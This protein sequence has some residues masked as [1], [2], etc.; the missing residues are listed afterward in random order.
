LSDPPPPEPPQPDGTP[1]PASSS[2]P[3]PVSGQ[4]WSSPSGDPLSSDP[5]VAG[6]PAAD[7][8]S[9]D[10]YRP[11]GPPA[12]PTFRPG[13]AALPPPPPYG[14]APGSEYPTTTSFAAAAGDTPSGY[15]GPYPSG[16]ADYPSAGYRAAGPGN[17]LPPGYGPQGY[18]APPYGPT[19]RRRSTIPLIALILAV[20]V[21]LCGGAVTAGVMVVGAVTD[22]AKEAVKPITEPTLPQTPTEAPDLPGLP[23]ELPTLPTDLPAFP[24]ASGRTITVTYEVTGDGPVQIAY[25]HKPGEPKRIADAKLPWRGTTTLDSPA[26][27]MVTAIREDAGSGSISCRVNVDGEEVAQSTHDGGFATVACSKW[28]LE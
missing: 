9:G 16:P 24:G 21:L 10:R 28:V 19:R 4:P 15:G 23:T 12:Q 27:L 3:D 11:P 1:S 14:A 26:F 8:A 7:A 25:V 2:S 6:P 22:R 13:Y 18:G 5:L 20:G 17:P